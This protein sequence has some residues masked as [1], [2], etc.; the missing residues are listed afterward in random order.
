[1]FD[2]SISLQY[3]IPSNFCIT[4]LVNE[5]VEVL[6]LFKFAVYPILYV[7]FLDK[8]PTIVSCICPSVLTSDV[9]LC[10]VPLT[11]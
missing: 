10:V 2:I 7:V 11:F 9:E 3:T 1:M 6:A 8:G 4:K 5:Y